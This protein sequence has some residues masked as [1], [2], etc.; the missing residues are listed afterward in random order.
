MNKIHISIALFAAALTSSVALEPHFTARMI[1]AGAGSG[2]VDGSA[3]MALLSKLI[4]CGLAAALGALL[5]MTAKRSI[6]APLFFM[7]F[8]ALFLIVD[9]LGATL[10]DHTYNTARFIIGLS[11]LIFPL[12]CLAMI[13]TARR[14]A[15]QQRA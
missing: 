3:E 5:L 7:G 12:T 14:P 8:F 1:M 10:P 15:Q 11:A 4:P 2:I 9:S 6:A 13:I